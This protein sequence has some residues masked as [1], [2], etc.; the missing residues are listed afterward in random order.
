MVCPGSH[1]RYPSAE[2]IGKSLHV[3][4]NATGQAIYQSSKAEHHTGLHAFDRVLTDHQSGPDQ[5][6]TV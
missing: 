4:A 5:L 1:D 3:L 2:A 6:D